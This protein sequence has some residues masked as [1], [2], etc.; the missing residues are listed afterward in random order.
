[1]TALNG[2][3]AT[4]HASKYLQQLCKHFAHKIEAT[5]SQDSG[6]ARFVFGP[7]YFT[8]DAE[9]LS[10]RFDLESADAIEPAKHVIDSH[11]KKFAF[12]E[13]FEAM[14]WTSPS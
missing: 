10:V 12:R 6:V 3:F 7:A 8:A 4:Q 1:M 2:Y 5:H 11:L 9:K 14:I 13:D